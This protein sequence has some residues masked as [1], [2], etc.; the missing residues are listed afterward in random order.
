M[1]RD[2][3]ASLHGDLRLQQRV[4]EDDRTMTELWDD[5]FECEVKHRHYDEARYDIITDAILLKKDGQVVTVLSGSGEN[6]TITSDRK[7]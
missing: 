7:L 4:R 2:H 1:V 5:A 3:L 6:V